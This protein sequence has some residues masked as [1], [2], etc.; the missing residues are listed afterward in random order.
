MARYWYAFIPPG[1]GLQPQFNPANY[2]LAEPA[3][4]VPN[5]CVS[6]GGQICSIYAPSGGE[7]PSSPFSSNL[8]DY[9][10]DALAGSTAQPLGAGVRK[11][12]YVKPTT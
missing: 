3:T 8:E 1:A 11:F 10:T 7:T 9:I 6:I 4:Q 5:G 12:V 2:R